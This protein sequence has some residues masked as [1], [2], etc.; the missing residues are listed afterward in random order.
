MMFLDRTGEHYNTYS[1]N[2]SVEVYVLNEVEVLSVVVQ[3]AVDQ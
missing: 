1:L 2:F 3:I